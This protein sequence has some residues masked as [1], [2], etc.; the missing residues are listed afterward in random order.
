[1]VAVGVLHAFELGMA[2][3]VE[4]VVSAPDGAFHYVAVGPVARL[5]QDVEAKFVGH[6]EGRLRGRPGVRPHAVAAVLLLYP[7]LPPP[8]RLC[9]GRVSRQRELAVVDIAAE[10]ERL[11][12]H[13]EPVALGRDGAEREAAREGE[14][15][16][17]HAKRVEARVELA[18]VLGL[19]LEGHGRLVAAAAGAGHR[20]SVDLYGVE[21]GSMRELKHYASV[22]RPAGEYAHRPQRVRLAHRELS[23][24][25][26]PLR[27]RGGSPSVR[28]SGEVVPACVVHFYLEEMFARLKFAR[29]EPVHVRRSE[30]V[31]FAAEIAVHL[32]GGL[33]HHALHDEFQRLAAHRLR[34]GDAP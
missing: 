34:H 5:R 16:P 30:G 23:D 26:V 18:P 10:P 15:A 1:M 19:A 28:P 25:A 20:E 3:P 11:A 32:Q 27:L 22:R 13:E 31:G 21:R 12:V 29:S 4:G 2:E 14:S 24:Y 9:H 8:F 17:P 6:G 7:D 33:P